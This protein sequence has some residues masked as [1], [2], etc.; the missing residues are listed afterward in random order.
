MP[1]T[2]FKGRTCPRLVFSWA[3]AFFFCWR[4]SSR[5]CSSS[6]VRVFLVCP[7]LRNDVVPSTA[8]LAAPH[9]PPCFNFAFIPPVPPPPVPPPPDPLLAP[10]S[11]LNEPADFLLVSP[12]EG[13]ESTFFFSA[14]DLCAN[15][16]PAE[17]APSEFCHPF[18]NLVTPPGSRSS[19]F[20]SWSVPRNPPLP[21]ALTAIRLVGAGVD[22]SPPSPPSS[23]SSLI[24]S[25]DPAASNGSTK[26]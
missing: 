13:G 23:S 26:L 5:F 22:R 17:T 9:L 1:C 18:P 14:P 11:S 4:W 3:W 10:S 21:P 16:W 24:Q 19:P 8:P 25:T 6:C 12:L 15:A 2:G 7:A 20:K